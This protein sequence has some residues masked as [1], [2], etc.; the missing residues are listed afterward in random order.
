MTGDVK[1]CI[2]RCTHDGAASFTGRHDVL[3]ADLSCDCHVTAYVVAGCGVRVGT[4]A[5]ARHVENILGKRAPRR[6]D[7]RVVLLEAKNFEEK[8]E[9]RHSVVTV[10]LWIRN[11]ERTHGEN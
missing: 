4:L 8:D 1:E 11:G 10:M 2:N 3:E 7:W 9:M 5:G 6:V